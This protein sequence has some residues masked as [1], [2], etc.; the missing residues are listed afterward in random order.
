VR[1]IDLRNAGTTLVTGPGIVPL[2]RL[3]AV[4]VDGKAGPQTRA[5][6]VAY[7]TRAG[8]AVDAIFGPATASALLAGK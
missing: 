3:L 5:A 8:L 7:Q 6:L 2:Q 1:T 4:A